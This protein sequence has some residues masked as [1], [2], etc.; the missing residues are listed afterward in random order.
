MKMKCFSL[1]VFTGFVILTSCN[2]ES[3]KTNDDTT[4]KDTLKPVEN[5]IMIPTSAC[6]SSMK[7]K[8]TFKLK[9]EVFPNVVTGKLMYDFNEK[10]SNNGTFNGMLHGD[11]LLADYKFTSEGKL[12]TRQVIFLLKDSIAIEGFGELEE[13]EGKMII[14]DL[15]KV[16]FEK[17]II[18]KK[19][20]CG[21]Y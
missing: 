8:D 20:E 7:G 21:E 10:D 3:K 18:F 6:Y 19:V 12:S 2:N 11:T 13:K 17:G 1:F 4:T 15:K 5:K 16:S 9:V 14:K